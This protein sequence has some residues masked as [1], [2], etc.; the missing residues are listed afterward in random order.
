MNFLESK[1]IVSMNDQYV[2]SYGF[3]V[4][5]DD[6]ALA[7]KN[8]IE[9]YYINNKTPLQTDK[10]IGNS[11]ESLEMIHYLIGRSLVKLSD[12][13]FYDKLLIEEYQSIVKKYLDKNGEVSI[14]DLKDETELSRKYLIAIM[15]YFDRI[16]F[17]KRSGEVRISYDR[18]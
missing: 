7:L 16:K 1:S 6:K 2:S 11:L 12:D 14:K 5:F 4:C 15:E 13:L 10:I 3:E 8:E 18:N 9:S 17:T